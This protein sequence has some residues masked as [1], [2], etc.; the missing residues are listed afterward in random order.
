MSV[1]ADSPSNPYWNSSCV[2]DCG[3]VNGDGSTCEDHTCDN[4]E[5]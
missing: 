5:L 4:H 2:D 1:A 3:V